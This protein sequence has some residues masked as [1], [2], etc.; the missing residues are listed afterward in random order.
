M[1]C[2]R[3]ITFLQEVRFNKLSLMYSFLQCGYC[4]RGHPLKVNQ[5]QSR[6]ETKDF[7]ILAS[8]NEMSST[9][10]WNFNFFVRHENRSIQA[11]I[12]QMHAPPIYGQDVSVICHPYIPDILRYT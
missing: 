9:E 1:R 6:T 3:F 5:S 7:C 10:Q 11:I 2:R 8:A 4:Y 12:Q